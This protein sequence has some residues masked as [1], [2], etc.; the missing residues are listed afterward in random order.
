V[1]VKKKYKEAREYGDL[2]LTPPPIINSGDSSTMLSC[3]LD[4]HYM[5]LRLQSLWT[6]ERF[7]RMCGYLGCTEYEMSSLIHLP[8]R[9]MKKFLDKG[10]FPSVVCWSLT[11]M[12]ASLMPNVLP[13]YPL[14]EGEQ[15]V[16]TLKK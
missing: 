3:I 4:N 6:R 11:I 13:D 2:L 10:Y 14:S 16:P 8:H 15:L 5:R 12:E 7:T 1:S 9:D